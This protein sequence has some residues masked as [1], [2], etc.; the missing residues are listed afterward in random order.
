MRI[1]FSSKKAEKRWLATFADLITL[2]LTFFVIMLGMAQVDLERFKHAIQS[3]RRDRGV[4]ENSPEF[5][6]EGDSL[7]TG[8]FHESNK[9]KTV[10]FTDL[11]HVDSK[12]SI[13]KTEVSEDLT[14]LMTQLQNIVKKNKLEGKVKLEASKNGIRLRVKGKLLF[15]S[16]KA[17]L[18]PDAWQLI[19]G[20]SIALKKNDFYLLVEGHTDTRPITTAQFPSNWELSGARA[21]SVI[22]YMIDKGVNKSKLSAIGYADNY[23]LATNNTSEG[24]HLNRRVEFIFTK[25]PTRV[26]I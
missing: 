5:V 13:L 7:A 15:D 12:I 3:L 2:L 8:D 11:E 10:E 6:S 25:Y 16:G 22:R 14:E 20:I 24:R 23:P 18:K 17:E 19:N 26:V 4:E 9:V 1:L 21:A